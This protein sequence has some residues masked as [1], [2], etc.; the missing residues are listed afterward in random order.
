MIT[1]QGKQKVRRSY[2]F[3]NALVLIVTKI[4]SYSNFAEWV[5][6]A[7]GGSSINGAAP[8]SFI[9]TENKYVVQTWLS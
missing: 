6:F 9:Q 1:K 7:S 4:K 5:G 3:F 2:N 8:S